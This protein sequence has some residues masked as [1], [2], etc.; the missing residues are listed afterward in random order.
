MRKL[1]LL[2]LFTIISLTTAFAQEECDEL[3]MVLSNKEAVIA[4]QK[5]AIAKQQ[6]EIAY[7]QETLNL[8]NSKISS[9][10]NDV[11]FKITSATGDTNSAEV[12]IEG[13]MINNGVLR[14]MQIGSTEAFDPQ[15]NSLKYSKLN[16]GLGKRVDKLFSD[17]PVKFSAS[18]KGV[19]EGTPFIKSLVVKFYTKSSGPQKTIS[20][21]FKNIPVVW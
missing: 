13:L 11:T 3:K 14:M 17:V 21:A 4:T 6:K 19:I 8:I 10:T 12:L 20:V 15:G 18:L 1:Q 5:E 9:E 7:Y 2:S 16:I